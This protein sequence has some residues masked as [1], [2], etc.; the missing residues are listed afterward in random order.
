MQLFGGAGSGWTSHQDPD[1]STG[2]LRTVEDA[3]A[4]PISHPRCGGPSG[5]ASTSP[6]RPDPMP[7]TWVDLR[8]RAI[9]APTRYRSPL[10]EHQRVAFASKR[11]T[12]IEP[13]TDRHAGRE[14]RPGRPV[15]ESGDQGESEAWALRSRIPVMRC[16]D[17]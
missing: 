3:A 16:R 5:R 7:L 9:S 8:L 6:P 17:T 11:T 4:W 13:F 12:V 1:K 10:M 15:R 14:G 2:T